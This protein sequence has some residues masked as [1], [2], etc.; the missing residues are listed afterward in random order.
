[1]GL[2]NELTEYQIYEKECGK[3]IECLENNI[4]EFQFVKLNGQVRTMKATLN[5]D[6]IKEY[7]RNP[8]HVEIS[9]AEKIEKYLHE[10]YIDAIKVFDIEKEE[11]RTFKPTRLIEGSWKV[12]SQV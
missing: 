11:F 12:L 5:K 3:L 10:I 8:L 2:R 7:Y 9:H 4:V 6:L 1:M